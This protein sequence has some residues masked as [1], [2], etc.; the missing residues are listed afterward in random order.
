MNNTPLI[1]QMLSQRPEM[2]ATSQI[3]PGSPNFNPQLAPQP[4]MPPVPQSPLLGQPTSPQPIPQGLPQGVPQGIPQ[5]PQGQNIPK[6]QED[7]IV[8]ALIKQLER[9]DK[10]QQMGL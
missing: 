10:R 5:G 2:G 6:P 9:I 3:M 4:S 8:Q 7:V 1:Q